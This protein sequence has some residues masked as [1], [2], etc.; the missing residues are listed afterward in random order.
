MSSTRPFTTVSMIGTT[1]TC[2]LASDTLLPKHL[3]RRAACRCRALPAV[4]ATHAELLADSNHGMT[5]PS[6]QCRGALISPT[7]RR[8]D[9]ALCRAQWHGRDSDV[10][11]AEVPC[12]ASITTQSADATPS[13]TPRPSV[14]QRPWTGWPLASFLRRDRM[15]SA[16]K[17]VAL[18]T[19]LAHASGTHGRD[20]CHIQLLR[21]L[22]VN[23]WATSVSRPSLPSPSAPSGR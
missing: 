7:L 17:C 12:S 21:R 10:G 20:P 16:F 1:R 13:A 8:R 3:A 15:A 23:S 22:S 2:S 5:T 11:P 14:T 4:N 18:V 9:R 6:A 19:R